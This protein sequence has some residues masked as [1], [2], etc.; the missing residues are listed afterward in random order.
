MPGSHHTLTVHVP[1][2]ANALAAIGLAGAFADFLGVTTFGNG[3][4]VRL[5]L[6]HPK[7]LAA[8]ERALLECYGSLEDTP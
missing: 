5:S 4:A 7:G 6:R 8:D 3:P 2:L 1:S